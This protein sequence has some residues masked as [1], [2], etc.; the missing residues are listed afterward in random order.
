[1]SNIHEYKVSFGPA[2]WTIDFEDVSG[3]FT[4]VYDCDIAEFKAK[5]STKRLLL[6]KGPPLKNMESMEC[7][8]QADRDHV[9]L[10]F[11][12]VRQYLT[13]LGYEV[14]VV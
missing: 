4:F 8:T 11:E 10:M 1:M 14:V 6:Q 3:K 12:R 9:A 5:G 2:A 13:S 7:H